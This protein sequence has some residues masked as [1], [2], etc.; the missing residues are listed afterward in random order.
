[1]RS[2]R[3][4]AVCCAAVLL[5]DGIAGAETEADSRETSRLAIRRALPYLARQ[6]GTWIEQKKCN[7]CH[8]VPHALWAMNRARAA[9]FDVDPNLAKWNRWSVDFVLREAETPEENKTRAR[10]RADEAY[11]LLLAGSAAE[12]DAARESD[13]GSVGARQELLSFLSTGQHEDGYWHAGGRLPGQKRPKK[14]TDEVTTMWC[15]HTLRATSGDDRHTGGVSV[16][17]DELTGAPSKSLEHLMLRY[18]LAAG[19]GNKPQT[20]KL[21]TELLEH[22]NSDGGWG[23]LLDSD[24]DALATGQ[25]LYAL[26]YMEPAIRRDAMRRARNYLVTTQRS[27]GSWQVPSTLAEKNEKPIVASN[28]WG[29]AWAVIGLM[30]TQE[31]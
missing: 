12:V 30:Q 15:L 5:T 6:T 14:E 17:T 3:I 2:L 23:W 16:P 25:A 20:A 9:G 24:S 8:Q 13:G 27:D 21:R 7:S 26:S 28:D 11:Q 31:P 10:D 1:M 29:T 4:G 22:Q 19:E 18:L